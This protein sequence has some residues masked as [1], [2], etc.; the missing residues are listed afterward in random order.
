MASIF[1]SSGPK[2]TLNDLQD[3]IAKQAGQ[4]SDLQTAMHGAHQL[5]AE[6]SARLQQQAA[7]IE[8][9]MQLNPSSLRVVSSEVQDPFRKDKPDARAVLVRTL[10]GA[11]PLAEKDQLRH[12]ESGKLLYEGP[13]QEGTPSGL[14]TR[15]FKERTYRG[16]ML[17]GKPHG[18]GKMTFSDGSSVEGTFVDGLPSGQATQIVPKQ[19][20][21]VG[22]WDAGRK[23]GEGAL[24]VHKGPTYRGVWEEDTEPTQ[25]VIVFQDGRSFEGPWRDRKP[26]GQGVKVLTDGT[27]R[28][29][30]IEETEQPGQMRVIEHLAEAEGEREYIGPLDD[31]GLF[32]GPGT[33]KVTG[34]CLKAV[35]E[36]GKA[37]NRGELRFSAGNPLNLPEGTYTGDLVEG[38]PN[39]E[40]T[41]LLEEGTRITGSF[42][43]GR[44]HGRAISV[45]INGD[46]F[47]G[48]YVEGVREGM[49]SLTFD[50][51]A[52]KT[53]TGLWHNGQAPTQGTIHYTLRGHQYVGPIH[54]QQPQGP[55]AGVMR[56]ADGTVMSGAWTDTAQPNEKQI[57]LQTGEV[58]IGSTLEGLP[59]GQGTWRSVNNT[60][61][62]SGIWEHG[63]PPEEGTI[64][65][66]NQDR[67]VGKISFSRQNGTL[68][69]IPHG[70]GTKTIHAN[71][72][73][74]TAKWKEGSASKGT[75]V[76]QNGDRYEGKFHSQQFFAQGPG[77][78]RTL[79][80]VTY[81]G[82]FKRGML[83]H[84][85]TATSGAATFHGTFK[86]GKLHGQGTYM[87]GAKTY[88]GSWVEGKRSGAGVST[89]P[90][91][92]TYQGS[93]SDN[94]KH[95]DGIITRN[96]VSYKTTWTNGVPAA[97][98]TILV[99]NGDTYVGE[100]D[101][102]FKFH[103]KGL[104]TFENGDT[105]H[106][107]Y[108]H[109]KRQGQGK[110]TSLLHKYSY[111]GNWL[112]SK[113]NGQGTWTYSDGSVYTGAWENAKRHGEGTYTFAN[114]IDYYKGPW[115]DDQYQGEGVLRCGGSTY[116]GFFE[117]G[118]KH[119]KGKLVFDKEPGDYWAEEYNGPWEHGKKS[120]HGSYFYANGN[121]YH[122]EWKEDKKHGKG[123]M[124]F[125]DAGV[126]YS[127][128]WEMG[129]WIEK[130]S[131]R[132][133]DTWIATFTS[134]IFTPPKP[135]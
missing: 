8:A 2:I 47:E 84:L 6:Q 115:V 29:I 67:Y 130:E 11:D 118:L 103:G 111:D 41:L 125:R 81:S 15:Y 63:K 10:Q 62:Y 86:R 50:H 91:E 44:V 38:I 35:F 117:K 16:Q 114:G 80:G 75:I 101:T 124:V 85:G 9:Q 121:C 92:G 3:L 27:R 52:Q 66:L 134:R 28:E 22:A 129:K 56:L 43:E 89:H 127:G 54:N 4:L 24:S 119:G 135:S 116:T 107:A 108:S 37:P 120:G 68:V 109:G 34:V 94:Q 32:H 31:E 122:G 21:Y 77:T 45:K 7:S 42:K 132:S 60:F 18:L 61:A 110:F 83:H 76:Y 1:S 105:Y 69:G 90:T 51:P 102:D 25:G 100:W 128:K 59:H 104:Y 98:G 112:N 97:Q 133:N 72:K 82:H 17:D 30:S 64:L 33:I 131:T 58:Y 23:H 36:H 5:I 126:S 12:V 57:S 48:Q 123:R 73:K 49:G 78:L 96:G 13:T 79:Q 106:G 87:E 53:I 40:G 93:W 88:Q 70:E 71:G 65:Y 20:T 39:G 74:I 26:F 113:P 14:G 46:T 55:G 99:A 19:Y 95:G